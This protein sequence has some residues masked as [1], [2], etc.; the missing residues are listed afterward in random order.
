M[1]TSRNQLW[2]KQVISLIIAVAL[3]VFTAGNLL[4]GTIS[5][6]AMQAKITDQLQNEGLLKN[7]NIN[8]SVNDQLVTLTGSVASLSERKMVRDAVNSVD[9][10]L[11]L[12][13]DLTIADRKISDS[14]IAEEIQQAIQGN[15][16]YS[17]YDWITASVVDGVATLKGYAHEPYLMQPFIHQAEKTPG[18]KK[19]VNDVKVLPASIFD[20]EIRHQAADA[21][22]EDPSFEPYAYDSD[23][24][25]HFIVNNGTVWLMGTVTSQIDKIRAENLVMMHSEAMG[26]KNELKVAS[27]GAT[28]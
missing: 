10:N 26:I 19:V 20:D 21:V 12:E 5:D 18:V 9:K 11:M 24:P 4:A 15:T 22:Y 16:F 8:I 3:V 25:I 14:Q 28:S 13:D 27:G 17:M 23:V 7:N 6:Q 2:R 1:N